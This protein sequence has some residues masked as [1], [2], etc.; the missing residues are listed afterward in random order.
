[1][2]IK[3]V[4]R[5]GFK[6]S[7]INEEEFELVYKDIF[8]LNEYSFKA[9]NPKS[10][11][12]DCGSHIGISILYFKKLYPQAKIIAFEPNPNTF[13]LLEKNIQQNNLENVTLI[14]AA[15]APEKGKVNFYISNDEKLP[16]TW[17][18]SAVIN[19]WVSEDTTKTIEV[20]SVRL[21]DYINQK[22]DLLK[23]DVEGL[24]ELVLLEIQS[25]IDKVK[26]IFME[27]HGS[28]TNPANDSERVL[29]FLSKN[30][31]KYTVT[32]EGKLINENEVNKTDPYW[33][34]IHARNSS[35]WKRKRT[36]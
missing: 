12:L 10:F 28:S 30:K 32:Q 21:S 15:V 2:D 4:E 35:T 33:L 34:I 26:E 8:E 14:K 9:S 27:F 17:G 19:K 13:K 24:E 3:T 31:F 25:K 7:F 22:I 16:W 6:I 18:D 11:I 1:M 29:A 5:N 23:L 36:Y 20:S